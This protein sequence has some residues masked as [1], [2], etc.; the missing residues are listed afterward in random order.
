M[1]EEN[2]FR[3]RPFFQ[4]DLSDLAFSTQ[5]NRRKKTAANSLQNIF[6]DKHRHLS[7]QYN[8]G[9]HQKPKALLFIQ[10]NVLM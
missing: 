8:L 6:F 4:T 3:V 5:R 9:I 10:T 2:R 7:I 1:I